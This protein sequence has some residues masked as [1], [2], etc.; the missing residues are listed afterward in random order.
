MATLNE[1]TQRNPNTYEDTLGA[2]RDYEDI[3]R[4]QLEDFGTYN[5]LW[6]H[7]MQ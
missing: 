5:G 3:Q 2:I 7:F 4:H 6:G 1:K